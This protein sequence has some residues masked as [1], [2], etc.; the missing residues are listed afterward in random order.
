[1]PEQ[2]ELVHIIVTIEQMERRETT[3]PDRLA[4]SEADKGYILTAELRRF[5]CEHTHQSMM[6]E[7]K[8]IF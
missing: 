2:N 6:L 5:G 3:Y 1:M 7:V 8:S 4:N